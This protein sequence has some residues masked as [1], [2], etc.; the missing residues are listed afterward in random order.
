MNWSAATGILLISVLGASCSQEPS[1]SKSALAMVNG[2]PI[3][4]EHVDIMLAKFPREA[5]AAAGDDIERK[6]LESLVRAKAVAEMAK[7]TMTDSELDRL[8]LKAELY[9]DELLAAEYLSDSAS[10]EPVSSVMVREYYEQN[11]QRYSLGEQ[12]TIEYLQSESGLEEDD[13]RSVMQKMSSVDSDAD[14]KQYQQSLGKERVPVFFRNTTIKASLL[15][16][17]LDSIVASLE[18]G[19]ASAVFYGDTL[20]RVRLLSQESLGYRSLAEVS[21]E[22]RRKLAP[23]QMRKAVEQ[24]SDKA[25]ESVTVEYLTD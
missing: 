11:K 20:Y 12:V 15:A 23:V 6:I 19:Q 4:Q 2:Q 14:W 5:V 3:Y 9:Q 22:I 13:K 25:L 24:V 18:P 16:S 21:G 1:N 8:R 7:T 10:I 17:P